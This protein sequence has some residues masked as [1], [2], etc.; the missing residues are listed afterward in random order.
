MSTPTNPRREHPSTYFVQDRSSAVELARLQLQDQQVTA[1]MGGVLPEQLDP[2]SF[3]R[4]L[5]V[6]CGS[7]DWLI[8]AAKTY[9]SMSLL[10]GVDISSKMVEY[11]QTQAEAQ[12]VSDRV[13]FRSMDAL[14]MLEFPTDYFHLVNQR[15]GASYLR[16]WD[17]PKLLHEFR[18]VTQPGGV[19]RITEGNMA[20]ESSSPALTGL[21]EIMLNAFYQAGHL[22][23]PGSKGV[24]G[25]LAPL[26]RQDG[27]Q[28]VQARTYAPE[29]RAGTPE[30]QKFYEDMKL[31]FQTLL[32]FLRKWTRVPDDYETL[33]QQALSEMQQPDFMA[34]GSMLTAWG[35][36]PPV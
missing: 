7:G 16:K 36:K 29:Y 18:R 31:L 23:T 10:V 33:Y 3:Q 26:L 27:L 15:F 14:R 1:S 30:G 24:T 35:N 8:Q 12:G 22:L 17:W 32:P 11:A 28:Q 25:D 5:D 4:V 34:I 13:Q 9:P 19:I 20:M 21:F 2:A 6:G